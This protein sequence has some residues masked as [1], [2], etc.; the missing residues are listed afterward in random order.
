MLTATGNDQRQ[1]DEESEKTKF[2]LHGMR[3]RVLVTEVGWGSNAVV[4]LCALAGGLGFVA[5]D[6][7]RA[8]NALTFDNEE[9]GCF[10][11]V[12]QLVRMLK[13]SYFLAVN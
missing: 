10:F 5:W 2:E 7:D 8:F 4:G 9:F 11:R 1:G 13:G 3:V 12:E 6:N